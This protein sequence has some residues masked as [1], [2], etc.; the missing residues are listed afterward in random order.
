[1]KDYIVRYSIR[2]PRPNGPGMHSVEQPEFRTSVWCRVDPV[3]HTGTTITGLRGGQEYA[4]IMVCAENLAGVGPPSNI[5]DRVVT[6][7]R[8]CLCVLPSLAS[9]TGYCCTRSR[10]P[11]T[12][13]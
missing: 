8:L 5:I 12:P 7:G 3:C 2:E 9:L 6:K 11:S 4:D 10:C 13:A 1:M